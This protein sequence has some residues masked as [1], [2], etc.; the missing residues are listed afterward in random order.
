MPNDS[1]DI[2]TAKPSVRKKLNAWRN[3]EKYDW[4]KE[5]VYG[6]D[7]DY[8]LVKSSKVS[9]FLN[10]DGEANII[11]ANGLDNFTF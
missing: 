11:R 8:R 2:Q 3:Y 10:G 1:I 9:S 4:A 6:I 7:A 5:H